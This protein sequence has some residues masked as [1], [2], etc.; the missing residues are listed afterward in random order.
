MIVLGVKGGEHDACFA[1]VKDGEPVFVYEQERFNRV[2]HG[3][4]SDLTVLFEGLAEHGISPDDIDVVANCG[5]PDLVPERL[6]QAG[7]YLT[8]S[9]YAKAAE[10]VK[11]R[12][13]TFQRVLV[14]GGFA[15]DRVVG[16]RHHVCH[17]ASVFYASRFDDAAVLSIDCSGEADTAMLSHCTDQGGVNVLESVGV[18]H[19]LGRFY[20][21]VTYWLGW[22]FGED[23]KT[24]ALAA[25]GD[26]ERYLEK[27]S[28]VFRV[29]D[30]GFFE[31]DSTLTDG[32]FSYSKEEVSDQ[33]IE[34]LFGPRRTRDGELQ[35]HHMDVAAAAQELCEQV[36]VRLAVTLKKR[37]GSNALLLTGGVASNSVG[38]GA[39]RSARVF[40]HVVTYPHITD[41]G[42]ALGAALYVYHQK[43][44]QKSRRR[45]EMRHPFLGRSI[46][47]ERIHE[48]ADAAGLEG[49]QCGDPA[50]AA[51]DRLAAGQIVGWIQ[52]RSEIGPRALGNRSILG[53]PL[54][55]GIKTRIN[56]EVKHREDWRPFAPS[57]LEQDQGIYFDATESLPYMTIVAPVREEWRE[58]LASISHVDGTARVGSVSESF[59]PLFYRLINEFKTRSGIGMVLNTSFN[60]R[61]EPIVQTCTQ[62]LRLFGSSGMDALIIGDWVFEDKQNARVDEFNP[63]S[64]NCHQ[65]PDRPSL[66]VSLQNVELT[67][68]AMNVI[69]RQRALSVLSVCMPWACETAQINGCKVLPVDGQEGLIEAARSWPQIV[70]LVPW[71]ADRFIFDPSVYYSDFAE[72]CRSLIESGTHEL[73]WIDIHGQ[74]VL[75]RDVLYVHHQKLP[76]GVPAAYDRYWQPQV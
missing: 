43:R 44:Q 14:A 59:N 47:L 49:F 24:M 64:D 5:D 50:A 21:S 17:T 9:A 45:W 58:K 13:P 51:A 71:R 73:F 61:G 52:G 55:P 19:S 63:L 30:D 26:P 23:G 18:P 56:L 33:V 37:T 38:N 4:S 65:L 6:R 35:Q 69:L 27:L 31:F 29:A 8:G 41:S 7:Q 11:W 20:E 28:T 70:A 34:G 75:A 25:Y 2:K 15:E 1:L 60:D 68:R 40:D 62:A 36:M 48:A 46:D 42:T 16:V 72:V 67:Q 54:T 39:I 22:G 76:L 53:N 10:N 57:V 32:T 66:V 3:M 74:I 12:H